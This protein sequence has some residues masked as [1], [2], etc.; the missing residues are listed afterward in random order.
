MSLNQNP[1][2]P[3]QILSSKQI[4]VERKTIT[5]QRV[6]NS[7]GQFLRIIEEYGNRRGMI[8]VPDTGVDDFQ[9]AIDEV[10]PEGGA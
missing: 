10:M 5:V 4:Q 1:H 2:K 3:E 8:V 6:E 9:D 7:R